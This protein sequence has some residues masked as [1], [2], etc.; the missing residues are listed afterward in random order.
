MQSAAEK[1]EFF[2]T[3]RTLRYLGAFYH[4]DHWLEWFLYG[5]HTRCLEP[6]YRTALLMDA[7]HGHSVAAFYA[8]TIRFGATS[9]A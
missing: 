7:C 6:L 8:D 9:I 5:A 4:T 1:I 3:S 2:S